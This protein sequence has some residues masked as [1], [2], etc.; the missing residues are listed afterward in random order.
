M[1]VGKHL[2]PYA[3]FDTNMMHCQN[4][5]VYHNTFVISQIVTKNEMHPS[6]LIQT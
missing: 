2:I 3:F 5:E 6:N 1:L 4:M